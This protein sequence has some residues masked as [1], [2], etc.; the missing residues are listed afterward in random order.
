MST[1]FY[2]DQKEKKDIIMTESPSAFFQMVEIGCLSKLNIL[3]LNELMNGLKPTYS[4][5]FKILNFKSFKTPSNP[6]NLE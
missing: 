5:L 3:K 4:T 6:F 1:L 2:L